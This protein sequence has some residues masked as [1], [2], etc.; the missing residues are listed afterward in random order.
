MN[1]YSSN[2]SQLSHLI[3][4]MQDSDQANL[5]GIAQK[6]VGGKKLKNYSKESKQTYMVFSSGVLTGWILSILMIFLFT[7]IT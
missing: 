6:I 1:K 3:L 2:Y 4:K 5:L 7:N